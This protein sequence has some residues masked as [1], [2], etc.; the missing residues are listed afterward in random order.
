MKATLGSVVFQL[1]GQNTR[2]A[3]ADLLAYYKGRPER[4]DY[5]HDVLTGK[6][7]FSLEALDV[8]EQ[9][10]VGTLLANINADSESPEFMRTAVRVLR[11][12]L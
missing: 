9:G 1:V 11:E 7:V 3:L 2:N 5:W 8:I 6:V 4:L 10:Y 12:M